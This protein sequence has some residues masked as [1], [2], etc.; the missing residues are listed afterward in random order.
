MTLG[1]DIQTDVFSINTG[2]GGN[3]AALACYIAR[4]AAAISY[5][6][7][8]L[9]PEKPLQAGRWLSG[10]SS[11]EHLYGLVSRFEF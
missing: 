10:L 1:S 8:S 3:G 2:G 11:A 7:C 4:G 6:D 9:G 5:C